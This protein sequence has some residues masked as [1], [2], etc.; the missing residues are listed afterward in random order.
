M[1]FSEFNGKMMKNFDIIKEIQKIIFSNDQ[2]D[3]FIYNSF[4]R[5]MQLSP[6]WITKI[7]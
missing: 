2:E 5:K 4:T 3:K 6:F 1:N 7:N